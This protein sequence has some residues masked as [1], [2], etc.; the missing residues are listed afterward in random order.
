MNY[1]VDDLVS[2]FNLGIR[3]GKAMITHEHLGISEELVAYGVLRSAIDIPIWSKC[4][5]RIDELE[6]KLQPLK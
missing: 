5:E 1:T 6:V 2:A 4:Q 3:V